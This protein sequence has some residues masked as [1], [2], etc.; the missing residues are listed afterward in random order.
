MAAMSLQPWQVLGPALI[1][2]LDKKS[3]RA[4]VTIAETNIRLQRGS[5]VEYVVLRIHEA[6]MSLGVG[7]T[8]DEVVC[9]LARQLTKVAAMTSI[10][11]HRLAPLLILYMMRMV[12][13]L[14][15]VVIALTLAGQISRFATIE[16]V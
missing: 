13:L 8:K 14:I 16:D 1:S 5:V 15:K 10:L 11:F 6:M 3:T 2:F 9:I 12:P 7:R 4:W